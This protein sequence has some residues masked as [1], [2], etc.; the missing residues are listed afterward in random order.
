MHG[1]LYEV[2]EHYLAFLVGLSDDHNGADDVVREVFSEALEQC[3]HLLGCACT[4]LL[5]LFVLLDSL[6]DGCRVLF[7]KDL[8]LLALRLWLT[9]GLDRV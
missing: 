3:C 8:A 5:L 2:F 1:R 6:A 4:R 7:S 9:V